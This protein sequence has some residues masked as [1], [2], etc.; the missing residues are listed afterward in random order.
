MSLR[1]EMENMSRLEMIKLL[2]T[3]TEIAKDIGQV[4]KTIGK[5]VTDESRENDLRE[6]VISLSNEIGLR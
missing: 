4:K 1:N 6:K 5:G 3:R 2:K